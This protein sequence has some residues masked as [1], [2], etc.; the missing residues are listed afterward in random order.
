MFSIFSICEI[1]RFP[2]TQLR[3]FDEVCANEEA[4]EKMLFEVEDYPNIVDDSDD[5]I[6]NSALLTT[7]EDKEKCNYHL[8]MPKELKDR[9]LGILNRLRW[10]TGYTRNVTWEDS[11]DEETCQFAFIKMVNNKINQERR[12]EHLPKWK[13]GEEN[14]KYGSYP[15]HKM[16]YTVLQLFND[17]PA[18]TRIR[19]LSPELTKVSICATF[20]GKLDADYQQ[21]YDYIAIRPFN[22]PNQ[23]ESLPFIASPPPGFVPYYM[24]F[25]YMMVLLPLISP[26]PYDSDLKIYI[27]GNLVTDGIEHI[28]GPINGFFY[29]ALFR[30]QRN[31]SHLENNFVWDSSWHFFAPGTQFGFELNNNGDTYLWNTTLVDCKAD[32]DKYPDPT[33]F[34]EPTTAPARTPQK[35]TSV[36]PKPRTMTPAPTP[37]PKPEVASQESGLSTKQKIA[38]GAGVAGGVLVIAGIILAILFF[39]GIIHCSR[40]DQDYSTT[41][42]STNYSA[43]N[44]QFLLN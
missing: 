28:W 17:F 43:V 8:K 9:T 34:P 24:V 23:H 7:E 18:P 1:I 41:G 40:D 30:L 5:G 44:T 4:Y 25:Q 31:Y 29:D 26:N 33:P 13:I 35:T 16:A 14:C 21:Y 39:T 22:D 3:T 42:A 2:Q 12:C 27:N 32:K 15:H 10:L 6:D 37:I 36:R 38:I 20:Q 11:F 19:L